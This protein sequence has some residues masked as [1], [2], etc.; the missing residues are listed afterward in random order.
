MD[1]H[2]EDPGE[3]LDDTTNSTSIISIH[4]R[5]P[6]ALHNQPLQPGVCVLACML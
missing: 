5:P 3:H 6:A 1:Q 2:P 4:A